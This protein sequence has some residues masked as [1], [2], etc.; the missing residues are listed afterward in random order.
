MDLYT[1]MVEKFFVVVTRA[2]INDTLWLGYSATVDGDNVA[3]RS[4]RM[5]DFNNGSYNTADHDPSLH[6]SLRGLA[7]IVVND[8]TSKALHSFFNSSTPATW[9]LTW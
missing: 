4:F 2:K 5:G 6:A 9:T 7:R 1:F 3:H 8:P